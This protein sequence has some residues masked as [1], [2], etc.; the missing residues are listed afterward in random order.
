MD[1]KLFRQIMEVNY[2][3]TENAWRYRAI[4][5]FF[6]LQHEKLRYYLFP[7]EIYDFLTADLH[8]ASYTH[9]QLEHDLNQLVEWKNLIPRQ[10]TGKVK[11]IE[12]FRKKR[13]RYQC[14]PYTVEI[15]RM[16]VTLEE[17]GDTFGG[18]LEKTQFDR[19][20]GALALFTN[21][22]KTT[23]MTPEELFMAWEDVYDNFR[24]LAENATDYLA[25][26]GSEKVEEIMQ[27]EAILAY[28][29]HLTNYLRNFLTGLQRS[30]V[31]IE[32]LLQ[33]TAPEYIN[34]L[35]ARIAAYYLTIPRLEEQP[36]RQVVEE[37]YRGQWGSIQAWFL[38]DNGRDSDLVY[39]QNATNEVIRRITRFAQRLGERHHNLKSRRKDYLS[40]ADWFE[41]CEHLS[42]AH[43]LFACVFGTAHT[44]HLCG[45]ARESED[46]YREIWAEQPTE[47][48]VQ[49]RVRTYRMKVKPRAVVSRQLEKEAALQ[50]YLRQK[51]GEQQLLEQ[52]MGEDRIVL[53][54]LKLTDPHIR[55]VLLRW[56]GK[57]MDNRRREARTET[58]RR[59]R[60]LIRS[61]N[62]VSTFWDDGLLQMPDYEIQFLD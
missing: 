10:D 45:A 24:K 43:R 39:L 1:E 12:E 29:E 34:A 15:E 33:D 21:A 19:L 51:E 53:R 52:L 5:R 36:D 61:D 6:Y 46:I 58:G 37:G 30:S 35:T 54:T 16:L 18:S 25:Y 9:E 42:D 2:L 60:L 3:T 32:K 23:A 55:K 44:R 48:M 7:G 31:R 38:G 13:Y 11:S 14:T 4:L 28:K 26:L 20:Q 17:K 57:C 62:P 56:I 40:L 22:D 59:F 8:F 50:T 49:P 47:I 41:R 27:T